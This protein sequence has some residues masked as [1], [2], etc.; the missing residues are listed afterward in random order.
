MGTAE[1]RWSSLMQ[2][3]YHRCAWIVMYRGWLNGQGSN[4]SDVPLYR[5][6]TEVAC[7]PE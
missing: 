2:G 6:Q 1:T 5:L 4:V 3:R 7:P